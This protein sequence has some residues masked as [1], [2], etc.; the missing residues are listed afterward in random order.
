MTRILS[1]II[2]FLI[3]AT[4][5][6]AM[7]QDLFPDP[8]LNK[9]IQEILKRKQINKEKITPDDVRT[10]YFLD[11][12]GEGI[13]DLSGLEHCVNLAE[14]KLSDNEISNV[15]PMAGLKNIQSLYLSNNQI[16]DLTPLTDLVKMQHLEIEGNQIES[17]AFIAAWDNMRSLYANGNQI[18]DLSPLAQTKKLTS[19]YLH[20][21]QIKDLSPLKDLPRLSSLG[22]KNNQV[23]DLTPLQGLD[24]L[25]FTFLQGNP[26][27][28]LS[29][30]VEMAR[31]DVEGPNRFARFWFLYLDEEGSEE[32]QKQVAELKKLGVRINK[33]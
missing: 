25:H 12:R 14:V 19:L 17:L 32:H 10:I 5:H 24:D 33:Q 20:D 1:T 16:S 22:L 27:Q 13:K 7:A 15:T 9:V 30:L 4:T 21:N 8:N 11:A 28:D 31:K 3:L 23:A 2:A 6:T 29:P 18:S 26:I